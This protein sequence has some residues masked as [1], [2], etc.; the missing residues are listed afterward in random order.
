MAVLLETDPVCFARDEDND[1]IIPLRIARGM[2]A[3]LILIRTRLLLWR[4]ELFLDRDA[5][6]PW[7][8][9]EDGVVDERDAILGQVYDPVKVARA[10]RTEILSTPGVI[11]IPAL[12]SSFDGETRNL[13]VTFVVRAAFG[14]SEETT[15]QLAT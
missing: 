15:V 9:T 8:E 4:D 3:I 13:A 5:G 2:E 14:D 10:V 7:I 11:S 12:S 1:L 6:M